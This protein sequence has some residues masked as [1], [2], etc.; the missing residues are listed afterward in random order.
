MPP[1]AQLCP[2]P[3]LVAPEGIEAASAAQGDHQEEAAH[4]AAD[5]RRRHHFTWEDVG[6]V[7]LVG[8]IG[9]VRLPVAH[10]ALVDA[11]PIP[12]PEIAWLAR[13]TVPLIGRIGTHGLVIAAIGRSVA[14]GPAGASPSAGELP[15]GTATAAVLVSAVG[16]VPNAVAVLGRTVAAGS[17]AVSTAAWKIPRDTITPHMISGVEPQVCRSRDGLI[18]DP[19]TAG[20][21]VD[22]NNFAVAGI[23]QIAQ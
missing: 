18:E 12:T 14:G 15:A 1:V 13:V 9:A 22:G 8:A 10:P 17:F 23:V 11:A 5:N 7:Q 19:C 21:G 3:K 2:S 4:Q 16:T 20:R 6:A